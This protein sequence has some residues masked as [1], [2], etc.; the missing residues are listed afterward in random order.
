MSWVLVSQFFPEE[1]I[2]FVILSSLQ[3]LPITQWE[4][5][6]RRLVFNLHA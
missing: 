4:N 6:N 2:R 1:D 5:R 3:V